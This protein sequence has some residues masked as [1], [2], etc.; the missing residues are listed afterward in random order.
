MTNLIL[1]ASGNIGVSLSKKNKSTVFTYNSNR[2]K[3]AI[4]FDI[5]K[6]NISK[7]VKK[8]KVNLLHI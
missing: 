8:Y 3:G 7:L 4:K 1:G 5:R 2:L 6:D